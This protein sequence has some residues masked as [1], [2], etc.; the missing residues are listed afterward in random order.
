MKVRILQIGAENFGKG[1]RSVIAYNLIKNMEHDIF[2]NDFIAYS[3]YSSSE[4]TNDIIKRGNI[5]TI[6]SNKILRTIKLVRKNKYD[7]VHIHADHA[8]EAMRSILNVKLGGAKKIIV[9]AHSSEGAKYSILKNMLINISR[10]CLPFFCDVAVACTETA[11]NYMFGSRYPKHISLVK[12]GIPLDVYKYSPALRQKMRTELKIGQRDI[13][14]GNVGRLSPEKN[15]LFLIQLFNEFVSTNKDAKLILIGDG[16]ER[17]ILENMV[18][19]YNLGNKVFLL[20][21]RSDVTDLLQAIDIFVFP[22]K[23][24]GF[25]MAALEA[26]AAS[27]PTIISVGVPND[28]LV[29]EFGM[30]CTS[31]EK[32]DEWLKY[33][34]KAKEMMSIRGK[35]DVGKEIAE[36]GYDIKEAS[37]KLE[38]IYRSLVYEIYN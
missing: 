12:D 18:Q 36:K 38:K 7:I 35:R 27:L 31:D 21:N 9:H 3:P 20:G 8:Y 10:W 16:K 6:L 4:I 2:I 17:K 30:R 24:E 15:Q 32:I 34:E 29:T 23:R 26:Q 37:K 25:G 5:F 1:G 14:I 19:K 33:L 13:V 28:V 22:S 11:G